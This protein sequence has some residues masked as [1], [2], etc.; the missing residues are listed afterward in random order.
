MAEESGGAGWW[1][2]WGNDLL[3]SVKAK[4]AETLSLVKHDLAEFVTTIHYDTSST[5]ADTATNVKEKLKVKEDEEDGSTTT[6]IR[7]GMSNW[8]GSLSAALK[9]N[10]SNVAAAIGDDPVAGSSG[11][12]FD[13]NQARRHEIQTDP[14]T[15]CT[16][17]DG[18]PAQYEEW[19]NGFDLEQHKGEISELLV[20]MPEIRALYTKLVPAAVHHSLFWHRYFYRIHQLD[21]EE[22]RRAALVE[23]ANKMQ[24][25]EL[26][27]DDEEEAWDADDVSKEKI[28]VQDDVVNLTTNEP[29]S[30][31]SATE[32]HDPTP[33][34]TE[35]LPT[36]DQQDGAEEKWS[37]N[38]LP[39]PSATSQTSPQPESAPALNAETS[40]SDEPSKP[41]T[42][43]KGEAS[44]VS[45]CVV[46]E[47]SRG[48]EK[49]DLT[50]S[51]L[52][53]TGCGEDHAA[54]I[55]EA[56][57]EEPEKE[58]KRENSTNG[59][60]DSSWSKISDEELKS[61]SCR[62]TLHLAAD[63]TGKPVPSPSPSGRSSS[64]AVLLPAVPDEEDIAWDDD[65]DD[66]DVTDHVTAA[67]GAE[68]DDDDW[69]NW[70]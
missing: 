53:A 39:A 59:S 57:A 21:E 56:S 27:W 64:S 40:H 20:N 61:H 12:V 70:E 7:Q 47:H 6:V 5:I 38:K 1:G 16:D 51:H 50:G 54:L 10:I 48:Q 23:R 3:S 18:H 29:I 25:D 15:Y 35:Q 19:C 32:G 41:T 67:G 2:S 42:E 62:D 33:N 60:I 17:P 65:F 69:E 31:E 11:Q 55:A 43:L 22:K 30:Q 4:S 66:D 44:E 28:K 49:D 34:E 46:D 36:E 52:D 14:A 24:E 58:I 45:V 8:L 68:D 9:D 26:G 63:S 37:A 13:R